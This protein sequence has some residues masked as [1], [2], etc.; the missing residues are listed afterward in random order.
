MEALTVLYYGARL[1][2]LPVS[3]RLGCMWEQATNALAYNNAVLI[4]SI[5]I[6]I[7]QACVYLRAPPGNTKGGLLFDWFGLVC[8]ANKNKNYQ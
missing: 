3:I 5:E 8:F 2:A 4:A 7:L 1:L 6:L